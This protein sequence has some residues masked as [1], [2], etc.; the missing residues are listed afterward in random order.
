M[1]RFMAM[2]PEWEAGDWYLCR[3]AAWTEL[4]VEQLTLFP[5]AAHDDM[6]DALS[7]AAI[8][9][10][11]H[12]QESGWLQFIREQM[13][14][15]REKTGQGDPAAEEREACRRDNEMMFGRA[16]GYRPWRPQR[17]GQQRTYPACPRC[18]GKTANYEEIPSGRKWW[19]CNSGCGASGTGNLQ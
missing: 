3:H 10:Q 2:Q 6:C 15:L 17:L 19:E 1:A 13:R 9:L 11:A 5:H 18:G 8:W 14:E 7:Q 4:L 16:L 12:G